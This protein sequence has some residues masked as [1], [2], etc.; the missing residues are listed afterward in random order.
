MTLTGPENKAWTFSSSGE[1]ENRVHQ[2]RRARFENKE[3]AENSVKLETKEKERERER[4]RERESKIRAI[5]QMD[6]FSP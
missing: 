6:L 4:E 5:Y 2:D 1:K 3:N